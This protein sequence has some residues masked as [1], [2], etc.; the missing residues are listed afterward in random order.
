MDF[1]LDFANWM[2]VGKII[3][4]SV[5]WDKKGRKQKKGGFYESEII[6]DE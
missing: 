3:L 5:W 4:H 1:K 2:A 6:G